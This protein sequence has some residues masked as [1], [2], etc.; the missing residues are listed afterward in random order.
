MTWQSLEIESYMVRA[1]RDADGTVRML[2]LFPK[3]GQQ[4][5]VKRVR[6]RFLANPQPLGTWKGDYP[7]AQAPI[8]D[9]ADL[10]RILQT[11]KPVF[12]EWEADGNGSF[13]WFG[14][15]TGREPPGEGPIDAGD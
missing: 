9:F 15:S 4:P 6:I 3:P 5:A 7:V 14:L 10:Y 2:F 13:L 11:E 8:A 1:V 12:F